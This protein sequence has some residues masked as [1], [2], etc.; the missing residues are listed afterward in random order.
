MLRGCISST[1]KW[2]IV[3]LAAIGTGYEHEVAVCGSLVPS[4]PH[5]VWALEAIPDPLCGNCRRIVGI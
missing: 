4:R 2:H 5:E 3:G 1:G